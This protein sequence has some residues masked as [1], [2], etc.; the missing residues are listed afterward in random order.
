MRQAIEKTSLFQPSPRPV[1]HGPVR[2]ID[3][4][5]SVEAADEVRLSRQGRM[6]LGLF[7]TREA[8]GF[9]VSTIDLREVGCQYNA[10]LWELRRYLAAQGKFIDRVR[11]DPK[12][13]GV[14]HYK[15]VPFEASTFNGK[16]KFLD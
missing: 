1:S 4:N 9:T 3:L 12:A 15:I 6:M 8:M 7:Q 11:K 10:R 2:G 14:N 13:P 16:A 5:P